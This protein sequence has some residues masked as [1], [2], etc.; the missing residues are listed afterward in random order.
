MS[1]R[2]YYTWLL[3]RL[4]L[5]EAS[6]EAFQRLAW[7]VLRPKFPGFQEIAP[8]GASGDGGNDGWVPGD[9]H[10]IQV[11]GPQASSSWAPASAAQK[12]KD[13]FAKLLSHWKGVKQYIF[14]LNDRFQGVPAPVAQAMQAIEAAHPGVCARALSSADL[15]DWFMGLPDA[16]RIR[17]IGYVP[18]DVP[19]DL[20]V[21]A[22][23][24]VLRHLADM[25]DLPQRHEPLDL[26]A[27]EEKIKLNGLGSYVA[28]RLRAAAH[29]THLIDDFFRPQSSW[30]RQAVGEQIVHLY[31][32][33]RRA[34]PD[35]DA[36]AADLRFVS[37]VE[38]LR[39]P[40]V[41]HAHSVK[42]YREAAEVVLANYFEACDVFDATAGR[43]AP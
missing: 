8:W 24:E 23:G 13:D 32:D 20:S 25:P 43:P 7:Q 40:A 19:A 17:I 10:Y 9:G 37:M 38:R 28:A 42:A 11:Y 29:H 26:T 33:S 41:T 3:M 5:Y 2:D 30:Q 14:V 6:G 1:G 35:S 16:T 36:A 22:A 31:V 4:R 34:I 18:D 39:S 12:A 27:F 15:L 21:G